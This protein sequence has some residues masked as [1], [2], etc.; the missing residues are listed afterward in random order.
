MAFCITFGVG[1]CFIQQQR[2]CEKPHQ[3]DKADIVPTP[4][5]L[6]KANLGNWVAYK[7]K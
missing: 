7:R 6:L 1:Y 3:M 4:Y 5:F 2:Q